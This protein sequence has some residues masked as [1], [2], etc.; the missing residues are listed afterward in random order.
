[1]QCFKSA[2]LTVNTD[3]CSVTLKEKQTDDG[4]KECYISEQTKILKVREN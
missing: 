3:V 2:L 4:E 1:M